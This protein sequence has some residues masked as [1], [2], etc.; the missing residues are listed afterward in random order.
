[1]PGWRP[2]IYSNGDIQSQGGNDTRGASRQ[3][4]YIP[5]ACTFISEDSH[6]PNKVWSRLFDE[7][8]QKMIYSVFLDI[9]EYYL[10]QDE[11]FSTVRLQL[12]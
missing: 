2:R 6:H 3:S 11:W 10:N 1:M 4:G 12:D 8:K 9:P 5:Y 7:S